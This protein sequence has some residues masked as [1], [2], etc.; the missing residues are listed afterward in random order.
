MR[1]KCRLLNFHYLTGPH[2]Y[3]YH[4]NVFNSQGKLEYREYRV[5][6]ES[7]DGDQEMWRK[8]TLIN[9]L[10]RDLPETWTLRN[11]VRTLGARSMSSAI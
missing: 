3:R 1:G 5:A 11:E 7:D 10:L 6:L 2:K 9:A 4:F 8:G